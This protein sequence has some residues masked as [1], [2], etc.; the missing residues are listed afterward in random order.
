MCI[1]QI[2]APS[3]MSAAAPAPSQTEAPAPAPAV[4]SDAAEASK[5]VG[6]DAAANPAPVPVFT[7]PPQ[8]VASPF[9]ASR[10]DECA[11]A[12]LLAQ[13]HPRC[14]L[15]R[16]TMTLLL[17]MCDRLAH[18]LLYR[19]YHGLNDAESLTS[20][21]RIN[22]EGADA[23]KEVPPTEPVD[24]HTVHFALPAA[25]GR[26]TADLRSHTRHTRFSVVLPKLAEID[27]SLERMDDLCSEGAVGFVIPLDCADRW[28]QDFTR[29]LQIDDP[30]ATLPAVMLTVPERAVLCALVEY[31]M[32]EV[33]EL[34]GN[35]ALMVNRTPIQ[36]H[37]VWLAIEGDEELA[38]T[39]AQFLPVSWNISTEGIESPLQ[40]AC[41]SKPADSD[42]R[43]THFLDAAFSSHAAAQAA[44]NRSSW[45]M[46]VD[47]VAEAARL[48]VSGS[49]PISEWDRRLRAAHVRPLRFVGVTPGEGVD[50]EVA[51]AIVEL[52]DVVGET[53][54]LT[55]R[56]PA[57]SLRAI[58]C[59]FVFMPR[60][61][62]AFGCTP[63]SSLLASMQ[64]GQQSDA[65]S[66][67]AQTQ[68]REVGGEPTCVSVYKNIITQIDTSLQRSQYQ[69]HHH[70]DQSDYSPGLK[71]T[72]AESV[73]NADVWKAMAA[74]SGLLRFSLVGPTL[75]VQ[76]QPLHIRRLFTARIIDES[77]VQSGIA[78]L[79]FVLSQLISEF[80]AFDLPYRED[81]AAAQMAAA[82][83]APK[84]PRSP[85]HAVYRGQL[86]SGVERCVDDELAL[87]YRWPIENPFEGDEDDEGED[88]EE[89]PA[90]EGMDQ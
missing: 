53:F 62:S 36:V 46:D 86:D 75:F 3:G 23:K 40:L 45:Y 89:L 76:N 31:F 56:G 73:W 8:L 35:S 42:S 69:P 14:E 67:A 11:L 58:R 24:P 71:S 72:A 25:L 21:P 22:A 87:T 65:L 15:Y 79:P 83:F 28:I 47:A 81:H 84:V 51:S 32:A 63:A 54:D 20:K 37:D 5:A 61:P 27:C 90:A 17:R 41:A 12:M 59:D 29:G 48:I 19:A 2:R 1:L 60:P 82:G 70:G 10:A 49:L 66:A 4:S 38:V 74:A 39:L 78:P 68:V 44:L 52:T 13:I 43:H 33:L 64:F 55:I 6:S 80:H 77:L 57:A 26:L 18:Y 34:A 7:A 88:N 9:L 30:Q 85:N 16:S 50:P